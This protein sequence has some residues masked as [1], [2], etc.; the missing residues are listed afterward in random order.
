M[1]DGYTAFECLRVVAGRSRWVYFR[2]GVGRDLGLSAAQLELAKAA[3]RVRVRQALR[4]NR[5]PGAPQSTG[6][7]LEQLQIAQAPVFMRAL[8]VVGS[9]EVAIAW[10]EE[11]NASLGDL[12]PIDALLNENDRSEIYNILGRIEHGVLS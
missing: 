12:R 2:S 5:S 6:L 1:Q 11:P 8:E 3:L 7:T 10:M 9:S 4:I